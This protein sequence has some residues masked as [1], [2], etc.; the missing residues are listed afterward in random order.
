MFRAD[1]FTA[2]RGSNMVSGCRSMK[3]EQRLVAELYRYIAPFIDASKDVYVSLDGQA[4][5]LGV[6]AKR[7]LDGTIPDLWFTLIGNKHSSHI[8]AKALNPK[9]KVLLMQSQLRAW[10]TSGRGGH[11]PHFWVAASNAFDRFYLWE[12][13][14]FGGILERSRSKQKTVSVSMLSL[15]L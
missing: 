10:S 12:Q 8:E 11:K 13:A 2:T 5:L 15:Q 14:D 1:A 6:Q 4:A 9:N 7:F 3:Q